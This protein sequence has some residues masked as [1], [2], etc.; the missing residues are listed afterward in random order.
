MIRIKRS[1]SLFPVMTYETCFTCMGIGK[2]SRVAQGLGNL[3]FRLRPNKGMALKYYKS[4][5][6][7]VFR[8]FFLFIIFNFSI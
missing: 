4:K 2:D 1:K 7:Y 3:G 6:F 8:S 5:F